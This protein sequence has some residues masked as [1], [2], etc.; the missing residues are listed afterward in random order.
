M[1]NKP[2]NKAVNAAQRHSGPASS[3]IYYPSPYA[4]TQID[5]TISK[6]GQNCIDSRQIIDEVQYAT[7]KR[8]PRLPKADL[9]VYNYPGKWNWC[10]V[11]K[12]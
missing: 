3:C 7:V 6:N 8:T 11:T 9:H 12:C 5:G 4:T 2:N 10:Y 1:D